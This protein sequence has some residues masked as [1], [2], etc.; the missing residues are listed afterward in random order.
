MTRTYVPLIKLLIEKK[1]FGFKKCKELLN[2][3]ISITRQLSSCYS[4]S[5]AHIWG[6][7]A[8]NISG[9]IYRNVVQ[10]G[11]SHSDEPEPR[12]KKTLLFKPSSFI[13]WILISPPMCRSVTNYCPTSLCLHT[14]ISEG[15]KTINICSPF[16]SFCGVRNFLPSLHILFESQSADGATLPSVP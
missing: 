13:V 2:E 5:F 1:R 3:G 11:G 6:V 7:A 4:L 15:E 16:R 9:P 12:Y 8:C 10:Y 14:R